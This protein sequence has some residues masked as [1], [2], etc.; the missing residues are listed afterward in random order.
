VNSR[1]AAVVGH[2]RVWHNRCS[3]M[4]CATLHAGCL[5]IEPGWAPEG[6]QL[7]VIQAPDPSMLTQDLI[8]VQ[9]PERLI[10]IVEDDDGDVIDFDWVINEASVLV[11]HQEDMVDEFTWVSVADV[12]RDPILDGGELKCFVAEASGHVE[13]ITWHLEVPQ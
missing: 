11:Q 5:Y 4:I 3:L 6:N 7:F 9:D 1:D 10:V 2:A 13:V 8:M 12:P